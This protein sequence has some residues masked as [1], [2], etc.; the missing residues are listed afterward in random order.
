MRAAKTRA[1][2]YTLALSSLSTL[3][4]AAT[5][6]GIVTSADG[7][8]IADAVVFVQDASATA[9]APTSAAT[10]DQIDKTFVPGLLPIAVGTHVH[11]P[12]H[13]QIH[14]HVYSF[15][16]TK[17]FELPLYKGEDAMPVLFDK[18]GV[19]KVGCNIHDWMSGVILVLPTSWFARTGAD[20][21]YTLTDIPDGAHTLLA[22]HELSK[23][24]PE[25]T[26]KTV[27]ASASTTD[28]DF[29]LTLGA[30]RARP[31]VRGSRRD[32]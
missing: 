25:D 29:R 14:H 28:T 24:K 9:T 26:A 32:P 19:V 11:F 12:N 10:M 23:Q 8:P 17:T 20:G 6:T 30:A 7:K 22:W 13:D 15:S 2:A 1:L 5:I 21:R 16:R 18:A 3:C 31:A 27:Q 4:S